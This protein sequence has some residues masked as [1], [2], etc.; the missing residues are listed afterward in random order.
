MP[1]TTGAVSCCCA[2]KELHAQPCCSGSLKTVPSLFGHFQQ[3]IYQ[4]AWQSTSVQ[5]NSMTRYLRTS[6]FDKAGI[7]WRLA[8]LAW[9]FVCRNFI[10]ALPDALVPRY[11]FCSHGRLQDCWAGSSN[12]WNLPDWVVM[13][14]CRRTW[15]MAS[16]SLSY[17]ADWCIHAR[18]RSM[19]DYMKA[20]SFPPCCALDLTMLCFANLCSLPWCCGCCMSSALAAAVIPPFHDAVDNAVAQLGPQGLLGVADFFVSSK[21]DTPMRQMHWARRFFW[22]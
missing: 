16:T 3:D 1:G 14:C 15:F 21:Y 6:A 18:M 17:S 5:V 11:L 13:H 2:V 22:R 19:D 20:H 9:S 8:K 7:K 10:P 4:D 12:F